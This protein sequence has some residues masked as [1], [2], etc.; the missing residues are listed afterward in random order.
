M[1]QKKGGPN[2]T[3]TVAETHALEGVPLLSQA[4]PPKKHSRL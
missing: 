2:L 1:V 3:V 4:F